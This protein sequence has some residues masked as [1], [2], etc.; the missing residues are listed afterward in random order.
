MHLSLTDAMS[1]GSY[2]YAGS[3]LLGFGWLTAPESLAD[4]IDTGLSQI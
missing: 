3:F 2:G 1:T 4:G